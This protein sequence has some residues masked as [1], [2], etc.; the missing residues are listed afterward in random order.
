MDF[1]LAPISSA[2]HR[3]RVGQGSQF[4]CIVG[5]MINTHTLTHPALRWLYALGWTALALVALLQSSSQPVIG[6]AAPPGPPS[7]ERELLLA[8]GHVVVFSI[9]TALWWWALSTV[10]NP[11]AALALAVLI[12]L[13]MGTLTEI[14]Q[15]SMPD[16]SASW[17]DLTV[18]VVVTC[19]T[20]W[21][22]RRSRTFPQ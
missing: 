11:R 13:V 20:A 8:F 22:I 4:G 12:A 18:N 2:E 1:C 19:L 17:E 16:R 15:A 10:L 3:P 21:R 14:G 5:G 9:L 7:L 6:P